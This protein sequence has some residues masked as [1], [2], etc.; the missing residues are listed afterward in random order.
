MLMVNNGC[1]NRILI[2]I[3]RIT[4][5]I[6]YFGILSEY[7]KHVSNII[8]IYMYLVEILLGQPLLSNYVF[9]NFPGILTVGMEHWLL[10]WDID[11]W[12]GTLIIDPGHWL[13]VWDI[14]YWRGTLTIDLGH[15]VWVSDTDYWHRILTF[16]LGHWLLT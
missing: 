1:P 6:S 10:A 11:Y 3:T 8:S 15:W 12:H 9:N 2:L 16:G 5:H 13:L 4:I 14:D 7:W